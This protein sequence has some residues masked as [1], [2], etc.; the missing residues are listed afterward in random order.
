[1]NCLN[2]EQELIDDR[3]NF[4][5][6]AETGWTEFRTTSVIAERLENLGYKVN[7]GC[8]IIEK[9]SVMGRPQNDII[10]ENIK[11]AISQGAQ[12]K[13]INKMKGYTGV[14]GI[15]DTGRKGKNMALRFDI[16]A[17]DIVESEDIKHRPYK[18]GFSSCNKG[19]M[20][21]C[22]HD[23]HIALG[24]AVAKVLADKKD[25]INGKII[26]IFQPAEE[27][28]RGA[29]AI[30]NKGILKDIDY[31][32]SGH[33]GL[34][35]PDGKVTAALRGFLCTTK[36]DVKYTGKAA[37]AG[38]A[39]NEGNNALLAAS[40]AMLNIHAIPSHR[41]GISRV[42][43]GKINAGIARNIVPPNAFMEIE[44]R[45]ETEEINK[46]VYERTIQ[47][48]KDT[49][50]MYKVK[51]DISKVGESVNCT[52]DKELFDIASNIASNIENIEWIEEGG[53][54]ECSEDVSLMIKNVQTQGG[55]ALY[56]MFG[57]DVFGGHHNELFDFNE[58]I[59]IIALKMY[60]NIIFYLLK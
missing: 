16:D 29:K 28:V 57:T 51:C 43:V 55:K 15:L 6:Y 9:S 30:V 27:G 53:N 52:S 32:I 23:G 45:G 11:R 42:N 17:N 38:V 60:T 10:E 3:R 37:H 12:I 4:H 56:L 19:A 39:P 36:I 35:I 2:L 59:L 25:T 58:S 21:A 41:D 8:E 13:W 44:T 22:G 31:F 49:A 7:V 50:D 1:M 46:Y 54:M 40:S 24:L 48:L 47:I 20:H 14:I 18:E 34:G 26:L 5:K 33:I